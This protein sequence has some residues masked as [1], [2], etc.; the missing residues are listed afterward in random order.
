MDLHVDRLGWRHRALAAL[1][2]TLVAA[3]G[4]ATLGAV[5]AEAVDHYVN[6]G[7]FGL[8]EMTAPAKAAVD[9][10]TGNVLVV[11]SGANEVKVY[12]PGGAATTLLTSFGSSELSAPY[13][14]AI[15]Q[16]SHDVYVTDSGNGRV[17]RYT[18]DGQPTPTYTRDLAYF[19]PTALQVSSFASAIA[20]DPATGDLLLADSTGQKVSR[21]APNGA[22]LGSFTG[23]DTT[24][25]AFQNLLDIVVGGGVTYV[26]DTTGPYDSNAGAMTGTSRLERFD[27]AGA[28]QGAL[29]NDGRLDHARSLGYG[30]TTGN[31][32]VVEQ[33]S[34]VASFLHVYRAGNP[35]ES[36][37][38]TSDYPYFYSGAVGVTVDDGSPSSS[39]RVYGV[40]DTGF[41]SF[42][43]AGVQVFDHQRLPDVTLDVPTIV[44]SSTAHL[45]GSV[46]AVHGTAHSHFEYS[47]D[48]GQ[49]WPFST[50]VVDSTG[51]SPI[52]ADIADLT[53]NLSYQVR[54]VAANDDGTSTSAVRTF[55][56]ATHEPLIAGER[57]IERT[58]SS[59]AL[60]ATVNPLGL[61]TTYRFEYGQTTAYGSRIPAGVDATAGNG[62]VARAVV[63]VVGGLQPATTYHFRLVAQNAAGEIV[64]DDHTFTT[65]GAAATPRAYELVSPASKGGNNV[66]PGQ[67]FQASA[68]GETFA[69]VGSTVLPGL[70]SEGAPLHPRYVAQRSDAGWL[71][72]ATDPPQKR[73]TNTTQGPFFTTIAVSEDGT[74]AIVMSTR[75][76]AEGAVEDASNA[77]LRD[78]ATGELTTMTT[79]PGTG[80][81]FNQTSFFPSLFVEGTADFDHILLR[82]ASPQLPGA[83]DSTVYD[84]TDGQLEFASLDPSGTPVDTAGIAGTDRDKNVLSEDG[85]RYAFER[86]TGAVYVRVDGTTRAVSVSRR[87]ADAGTLRPAVLIGTSDDLR[88]VFL[89]ATDLTEDSSP[90]ILSL[91]RYDVDSDQLEMLAPGEPPEHGTG[92]PGVLQVSAEGG[93]VYFHAQVVLAPGADPV[94]DNLYVWR[95]GGVELVAGNVGNLPA[96]R[97]STS[98]RYFTFSSYNKVTD[99][100][101][102]STACQEQSDGDPGNACRVVYRYDADTGE[103]A[104][105]SCRPDGKPATG[106]ARIGAERADLGGH[107]FGR[108]VDDSGRVYFDT[109]D[110]LVTGDV[111]SVSDVYVFDGEDVSLISSGRGASSRFADASADGEDVFLS[112]RSPLVASDT[113]TATDVY[114]ARAGG[115]IPAQDQQPPSAD[116]SGEDCRDVGPGPASSER[117]PSEAVDGDGDVPSKSPKARISRLQAGFKGAVLHL[118][119]RVSG[120]GRIRVSGAKVVA[121]T[122]TA[123]RAGAYRLR[124]RLTGRQRALRRGGRRVKAA[125]TVSFTPVF[126]AATKTKLTRT[127]R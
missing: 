2:A 117:A 16:A 88:E 72:K 3:C 101:P 74:K 68:D 103:L 111:N 50:P 27:G 26:L 94:G 121:V 44:T 12:G 115:G 42:G 80:D 23:A 76:L 110:P 17:L 81:Y 11:D 33:G 92:P 83:P 22:L 8:G 73:L 62:R 41:L 34:F 18:T 21:F 113:D 10:A 90:G 100:D 66:E 40:T 67:G 7:F 87:A 6:A 60:R 71:S 4:L 1:I 58:P 109:P 31:L 57:A 79:V 123:K 105:A 82:V 15:D 91:Y 25:G 38:Y 70:G 48:G 51:V 35:L 39:G 63:Q 116:C 64:G 46:D 99:Y 53:P 20:V 43:V 119:L 30:A 93:V 78:V 45:S 104:C 127:A 125:M 102:A 124:V 61:Q 14:I 13:G 36:V 85:S 75:A 19:G 96:W 98:G 126:G 106:N 112:T 49:T 122:R 52:D 118:S 97:A 95:D 47:D 65:T 5:R 59:A 84:F 29:P 9:D 32:F 108:A 120:P 28:S 37:S 107:A 55:S 86:S 114:D 69:F 54:L 77:Y 56:T 89:I 24:A